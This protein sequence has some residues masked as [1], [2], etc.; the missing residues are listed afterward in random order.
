MMPTLSAIKD[1]RMFSALRAD[2][3]LSLYFFRHFAKGHPR[4]GF[5]L[6]IL[7]YH[8]VSDD[9]ETGHPYYWINT[10]PKRFAEQMRFLAENNYKVILFSEA[11]KLISSQEGDHSSKLSVE[12][13]EKEAVGPPTCN[14]ELA[15]CKIGRA[16]V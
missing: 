2:R 12:V 3:L 6:P 1:S 11:V 9:P 13:T 16:H 14:L 7:M 8:S 4:K 15:T 5:R 10:S